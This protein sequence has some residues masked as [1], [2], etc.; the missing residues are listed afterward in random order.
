[1]KKS[2]LSLILLLFVSMASFAFADVGF[3]SPEAG[4]WSNKQMLVIDNV[5]EGEY[6]Y[7]I[8]GSDPEKSGFAYDGPVLL[9]VTGDVTLK[10][11]HVATDGS[12]SHGEVK[13]N[14]TL[15]DGEKNSYKP[16]ISKFYKS[17]ILNYKSGEILEIPE[18]LYFSF[19]E[20]PD[21]Y[22]FGNKLYI[23][24]N[25]ILSRYIPCTVYD[26]A[27]EL[28]WH[29]VI[30][31]NSS[32]AGIYSK[33][34]VPFSVDDWET[35]TFNDDKLIYKI[36]SELWGQP[37]EPVKLDRSV[38]HMISWQSVDYKV[39]NVVEYFV[40][41]PKPVVASRVND[42]GSVVFEI[43]SMGAGTEEVA[44][45][46][47]SESENTTAS[48]VTAPCYALGVLKD[49]KNNSQELFKEVYVDAFLGEKI[50]GEVQL[51]VFADAVYQGQLTLPYNIDKVPPLSPVIESSAKT[52]YS[53][54][55]VDVNINYEDSVDLY[56]ALSTPY[57]ID[58]IRE[59]YSK[60]SPVLSEIQ[61]NDYEVHNDDYK[62]QFPAVEGKVIYYKVA[63]YTKKGLLKSNVEEYCVVVDQS[64]YYFNKDSV[65]PLQEGTIINPFTKF[66][67]CVEAMKD[68]RSATLTVKGDLYIDKKYEIHSNLKIVNGGDCRI[69]FGPK[70]S[71]EMHGS[72]LEITDCRMHKIPSPKSTSILPFF[73]LNHGALDMKNCQIAG[74]F[75]KN[76]AIIDA[77]NSIVN[78]QDSIVSV[79][80]DYYSSFISC[81]D[82]RV[83]V[84]N[85]SITTTGD[86]S[87]VI[88]ANNGE[89]SISD[90]KFRI[91]GKTG[92][93]A[94]L[95]GV[96]ARFE[97]N[98]FRTELQKSSNDLSPIF[99]N[100]KTILE[101]KGNIQ[102]GF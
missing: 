76:G 81:I 31:V 97:N 32:V 28:K 53:R 36:D 17:G 9:D 87:V 38:S 69:I 50:S 59:V 89:L 1:M 91:I 22:I 84:F 100:K 86:T 18:P 11:T 68:V 66:Q 94:E 4:S 73:K 56:V 77:L 93:I 12:K 23:S 44:D 72:T 39:G 52:F 57:E 6:Y 47:V 16:F 63:A 21:F 24:N 88:S 34:E 74:D 49:D 14:V 37:T 30:N 2:S 51:A 90:N 7:S 8:N 33:R 54:N 80:A 3:I 78:V 62:L 65:A 46:T 61:L 67:Q 29:F 40:L 13:Y 102:I 48:D 70:G 27:N 60:D 96:N 43:E 5:S 41:P 79:T 83:S 92:R 42:D 85:S 55:G 101:E 10:V 95:F 58:N 71:I 26:K 75:A 98:E 82:S 19:E 15:N 25:S 99:V 35:I 64:G 45:V 20:N